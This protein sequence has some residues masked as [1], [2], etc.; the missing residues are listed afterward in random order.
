MRNTRIIER[1]ARLKIFIGNGE[2]W[3]GFLKYPFILAIG[4]KIYFPH[5]DLIKLG[6]IVLL[7]VAFLT[8]V[9]WL[10]LKY[11]KLTPTVA[12]INTREYNPYFKK[13][14]RKV[15]GR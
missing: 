10:D 7:A 1:L 8:F 9:G 3:F 5:A 4:L 14:E 6:F 15:N 13:L 11:I 12:E 2:G